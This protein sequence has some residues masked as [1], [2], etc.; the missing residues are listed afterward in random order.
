MFSAPLMLSQP[1]SKISIFIHTAFPET[2]FAVG[3]HAIGPLTHKCGDRSRIGRYYFKF[4][5]LLIVFISSLSIHLL[6]QKLSHFCRIMIN[7]Q[8]LLQM[9]QKTF[10]QVCTVKLF[11]HMAGR[12]GDGLGQKCMGWAGAVNPP[13][14]TVRGGAHYHQH[15]HQHYRNHH[16]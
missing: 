13:F 2:F 11:F 7:T 9:S 14:S 8:L 10:K 16:Q 4:I 1:N 15:H 12:G 5:I 6:Y 3:E